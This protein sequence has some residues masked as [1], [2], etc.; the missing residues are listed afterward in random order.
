MGD[1]RCA[2]R[3]AAMPASF[4]FKFSIAH[5]TDYNAAIRPTGA[6]HGSAFAAKPCM[7]VKENDGR[8]N[9]TNPTEEPKGDRGNGDKTWSPDHG[10]QG[11][12]NRPDGESDRLPAGVGTT[13]E[14]DDESAFGNDDDEEHEENEDE[15]EDEDEDGEN[16]D[17]NEA[18][19]VEVDREEKG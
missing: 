3:H 11:I 1:A 5:F 7:D 10:E 6:G 14:A 17:E 16:E 2:R 15:D 9:V 18:D 12:S 8:P 19:D 4:G 13:D